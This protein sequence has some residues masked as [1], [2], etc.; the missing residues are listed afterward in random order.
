[1]QRVRTPP[2]QTARVPTPRMPTPGW[3]GWAP[4]NNRPPCH[5]AGKVV[6]PGAR[7]RMPRALRQQRQQ[8]YAYTQ[9]QC[10]FLL[11]CAGRHKRIEL[12]AGFKVHAAAGNAVNRSMYL[13][14]G[15]CFFAVERAKWDVKRCCQWAALCRTGFRGRELQFQAVSGTTAAACKFCVAG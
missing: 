15:T 13:R 10:T 5:G 2:T 11:T 6:P 7:D 8:R 4:S 12:H 1:M 3:L 9:L 14:K